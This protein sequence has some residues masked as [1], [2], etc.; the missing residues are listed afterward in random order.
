MKI[1]S[2]IWEQNIRGQ[3]D[4]IRSLAVDA[5][6]T[7]LSFPL[8]GLVL[9]GDRDGR[10]SF[11]GNHAFYIKRFIF[12]KLIASLSDLNSASVRDLLTG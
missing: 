6:V 11:I 7:S 8:A 10:I 1:G 9:Y 3:R 4:Q 5:P 12:L 2:K